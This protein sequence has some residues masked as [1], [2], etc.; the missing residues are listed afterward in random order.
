MILSRVPRAVSNCD[1]KVQT[2]LSA[3]GL[4]LS[5]ISGR[6]K[7]L[8]HAK[9]VL[10]WPKN[11]LCKVKAYYVCTGNV[12]SSSFLFSLQRK[13]PLTKDCYNR[14]LLSFGKW[15]HKYLVPN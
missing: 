5:Y 14:L 12:I 2:Q 3:S 15:D 6:S 8:M 4:F 7:Y 11:A 10:K 13:V 1:F 9:S